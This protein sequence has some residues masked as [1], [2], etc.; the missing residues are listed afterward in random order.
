MSVPAR[1]RRLG[2]AVL[3]LAFAA[4][5]G[6]WLTGPAQAA[7]AP[8]AGQAP[9]LT[10]DFSAAD[11]YVES[12]PTARGPKV[13]GV[14]KQRG[15]AKRNE[16]AAPTL[17]ARVRSSLERQSD[18]TATQLERIA[19]S[20]DYGAP[21]ETLRKVDVDPSVRVPAAA[22]SA[23]GDGEESVLTWLLV[24]L[25][26]ITLLTA[27]SAAYRRYQSRNTAG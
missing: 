6:I 2:I 18:E 21:A 10:D 4:L 20:P 24:A 13:P 23:S 3:V 19:T 11:Q 8:Q 14:G 12:V 1:Q 7:D 15:R 26:A 16:N 22:V 5:A 9:A 25:I 27:G 17:S